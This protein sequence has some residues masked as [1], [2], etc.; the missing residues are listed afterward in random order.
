MNNKLYESNFS[1]SFRLLN[2]LLVLTSHQFNFIL[3]II[4]ANH[5]TQND[6]FYIVDD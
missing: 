1:F 3:S 4:F 5:I 6:R 2:N